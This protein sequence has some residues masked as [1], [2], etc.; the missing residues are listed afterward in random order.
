MSNQYDIELLVHKNLTGQITGEEKQALDFHLQNEESK[1]IA[2][3]LESIW[4]KSAGAHS[5]IKFDKEKARQAFFSKL[6]PENT[7]EVIQLNRDYNKGSNT[8]WLYYATAIASMFI[9]GFFVFNNLS[10]NSDQVIFAT[11]D[12]GQKVELPDG[13]I[14]T[15]SR[16]FKIRIQ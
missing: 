11:N 1:Q 2:S 16:K 9:I 13:S 7:V 10:N 14:I 12:V 8:R 5:T 4:E 15:L 3:N 6:N